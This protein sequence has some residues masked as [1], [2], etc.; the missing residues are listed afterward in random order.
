MT[1]YDTLLKQTFELVET[2]VEKD[3]ELQEESDFVADLGFDS[4]KV[5]KLLER[6][7][8]HY[9]ISIPLNILPDI[10]TIKDFVRQLEKIVST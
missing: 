2:L 4:L 9:D 3:I 10:Q 6:V 1:E 7:E 5:M 8:D